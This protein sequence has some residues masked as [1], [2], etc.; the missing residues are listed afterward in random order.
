MRYFVAIGQCIT[1]CCFVSHKTEKLQGSAQHAAAATNLTLVAACFVSC[2]ITG[3]DLTHRPPLHFLGAFSCIQYSTWKRKSSTA[4]LLLCITI[5]KTPKN[6]G[7]PGNEARV[8]ICYGGK[9]VDV[10]A[11]TLHILPCGK[12]GD[13]IHTKFVWQSY[14]TDL[15][16]GTKHDFSFNFRLCK[17]VKDIQHTVVDASYVLVGAS[18]EQLE[19]DVLVHMQVQFVLPS[20][21]VWMTYNA[22]AIPIWLHLWSHE[23]GNHITNKIGVVAL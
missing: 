4:F 12:V 8:V 1:A 18:L 19:F 16:W 13:W 17:A 11:A 15:L 2:I 14:S 20:K 3:L 9:V 6:W 5:R 7:R 23:L 22:N 21:M 10:T